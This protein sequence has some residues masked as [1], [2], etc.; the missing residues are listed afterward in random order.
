[1]KKVF[2]VNGNLIVRFA[3][4]AKEQITEWLNGVDYD[5]A[6]KYA[7]VVK[8]IVFDEALEFPCSAI[9]TE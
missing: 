3:S 2:D 5:Y 4:D 1:M 6:V 9:K 7:T 8:D